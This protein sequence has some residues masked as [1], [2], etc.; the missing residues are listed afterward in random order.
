MT[1]HFF[2]RKNRFSASLLIKEGSLLNH[3]FKL[4]ILAQKEN[5]LIR[6]SVLNYISISSIESFATYFS[7]VFEN[8]LKL[9]ELK[10]ICFRLPFYNYVDKM[11]IARGMSFL[12]KQS[13]MHIAINESQIYVRK[14]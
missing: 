8:I 14:N 5:L 10:I 2:E 9:Q 4:L 7:I 13:Y 1:C 12:H 3:E 6:K 11:N